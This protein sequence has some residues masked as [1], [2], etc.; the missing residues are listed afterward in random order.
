M[1]WNYLL[2]KFNIFDMFLEINLS[3]HFQY[4]FNFNFKFKLNAK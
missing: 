3:L 4:R 2:I 1:L